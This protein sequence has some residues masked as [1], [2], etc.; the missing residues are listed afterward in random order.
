MAKTRTK[1]N[2]VHTSTL[3]VNIL[4][5]HF[6]SFFKVEVYSVFNLENISSTNQQLKKRRVNYIHSK[7]IYFR[8]WQLIHDNAIG[9]FVATNTGL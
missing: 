6:I 3:T 5:Q 2:N 7:C 1:Y 4:V 9:C 8:Q